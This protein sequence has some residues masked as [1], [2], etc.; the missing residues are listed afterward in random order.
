MLLKF[1]FLCSLH[2]HISKVIRTCVVAHTSLKP[3]IL[4]SANEM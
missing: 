1:G 2:F 4:E 3:A